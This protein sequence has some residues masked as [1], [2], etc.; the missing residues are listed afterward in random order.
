MIQTL[1]ESINAAKIH[2]STASF[3]A[4]LILARIHF[5]PHLI[6]LNSIMQAGLK[7]YEINGTHILFKMTFYKQS[8]SA[9]ACF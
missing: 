7:D 1:H 4:Q 2:V 8:S 3:N 9:M 5:C 6:P